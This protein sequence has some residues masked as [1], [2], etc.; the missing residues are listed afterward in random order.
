MQIDFQSDTADVFGE[1]VNLITTK[2]GHY[3]LPITKHNQA[4]ND[5]KNDFNNQTLTSSVKQILTSQHLDLTTEKKAIK[6]H[7]QF[8]HAPSP[9][10]LKLVDSS[11]PEWAGD[12]LLRK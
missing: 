2:S 4:L 1:R 8:A 11:G 6:L 7:K 3:A 10:L 9:K 12:E 5:T